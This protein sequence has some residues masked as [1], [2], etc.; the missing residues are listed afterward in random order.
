MAS[1]GILVKAAVETV[2]ISVPTLVDGLLNRTNYRRCDG[3]LDS[4]S[5]RLVEQAGIIIE[6]EGLAQ[7]DRSQSYVVMSN[8]QSHYDIP[9]VFQAL[10][11]PI[12]MVA[13]T[14]LFRIPIMGPA[15]L[16]SGFVEIDR[17]NSRKA[18]QQMRVARQRIQRDGLSIW[19]APEGTRSSDG[20]LG[21][22][23]SGGFH[24][25]FATEARILPL[26]IDGSIRVHRAGDQTVH[27]G[28]RVRVVV[29][30]ALDPTT[31]GKKRIKELMAQVRTSIESGLTR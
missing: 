11:I 9:I 29:H 8:H 20:S 27:L 17:Q 12:R 21:E 22:F 23:K 26:S 10:K 16:R 25:A 2:R 13:K 19:I 24:L 6:T 30:P 28:E 3:R 5:R 31:F 4:W 7:L 14:E 1:Y 18:I 15:M